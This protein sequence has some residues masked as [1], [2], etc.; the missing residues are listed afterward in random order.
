M[1]HH[2][3]SA[4]RKSPWIW[5][6]I[7]YVA[8]A[9]PYVAVNTLTVLLYVKMGVEKA[10][11]A[12]FTGW[13][14]LPWV[15][16]PFWSPL[17][18]VISTKR[19]WVLWMQLLMGLAFA[20]VA[21]MLPGEIF[22]QTTLALFWLAA[23]FSSTHDIA[24]DGYYMLE[25]TD[26]QQAAYVGVR[27]TFYRIGSLMA[28]GGLVWLAG[29]IEENSTPG[30]D[31]V[32]FSWQVVFASLGVFLLCVCIYHSI[33]LPRSAAD[34]PRHD[35]SVMEVIRK[36]GSTFTTFFSKPQILGGLAFM[37]LYRFPEALCVKMITPFLIDT[38][39]CG[40]LGMSTKAVGIAYGITGV[41]ALLLGG[42]IG[43]LAIARYGLK[44]CLWPM[45]LSLTLPCA[46]Y[47]LLAVAHINVGTIMGF[48]WVN[49]AIFVEQFGYGFGFT[50]FMLYL[51]YFSQGEWKTAHYSFCTAFMA[52]GMMLPGM[53]A[54]WLF[55]QC[56]PVAEAVHSN[57]WFIF[58][59]VV[60]LTSLFTFVACSVVKID[61]TFGLKVTDSPK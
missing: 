27:S 34:T 43:G 10:E 55:D 51:I 32:V 31:G 29:M 13:L 3:L 37:L 38:P 28:S 6:P 5:I 20:G 41:V 33:F 26:H 52:L 39:D 21:F 58:F 17:V 50:A 4:H 18:D 12:Y 11:M 7:L 35:T 36:F 44:R 60:V 19:R 57:Q 54:G 30:R 15:I 45:A 9:L 25:L 53:V 16:K 47:A 8:E 46:L 61:K 1:T 14:Y 23:F 24:A 49:V 40:G 56:L 22:F 2:A 48:T 42:I 59:I